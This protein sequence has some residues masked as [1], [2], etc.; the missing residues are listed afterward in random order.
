MDKNEIYNL[1]LSL[2]LYSDLAIESGYAEREDHTEF[3]KVK[4]YHSPTKRFRG[5]FPNLEYVDTVYYSFTYKGISISVIDNEILSIEVEKNIGLWGCD[6]GN[7]AS[8]I[9]EEL[10]EAIAE[11]TEA[12]HEDQQEAF[13]TG[14]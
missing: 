1:I 10:S 7:W 8:E 6:L 12:K 14:N 4:F 2:N 11:K 13:A 3:G 9:R 5:H